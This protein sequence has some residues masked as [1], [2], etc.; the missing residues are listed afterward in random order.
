MAKQKKNV[1]LIGYPSVTARVILQQMVNDAISIT[2]LISQN[3]LPDQSLKTLKRKFPKNLTIL[4]GSPASIDMGLSGPAY[5]ELAQKT[6]FIISCHGFT[7]STDIK[8]YKS[9]AAELIEFIHASKYRAVLIYFSTIAVASSHTGIFAEHDTNSS[10]GFSSTL[11]EGCFKAENMLKK[12]D[13]RIS[14]FIIRTSIPEGCIFSSFSIVT[15]I[16]AESDNFFRRPHHPFLFTPASFISSAAG[17]IMSSSD[18]VSLPD[19]NSFHLFKTS[20]LT[21]GEIAGLIHKNVNEQLS[22]FYDIKKAAARRLQNAGL[23]FFIPELLQTLFM[24]ASNE[25]TIVNAWT[26]S[27]FCKYSDKTSCIFIKPYFDW[28]SIIENELEKIAGFQ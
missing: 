16:L 24:N 18:K 2:L 5:L 25:T 26:N 8:F 27:V 11:A 14:F 19:R 3:S 13:S 21:A 7:L 9:E 12:S 17:L 22:P 6:D 28:D 1:L 4:E 20:S 10:P 23:Q 15:L